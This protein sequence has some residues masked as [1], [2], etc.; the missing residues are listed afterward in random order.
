MN[1]GDVMRASLRCTTAI[2][3]SSIDTRRTTHE[4]RT[5]PRDGTRRQG[6]GRQSCPEREDRC[7]H[8]GVPEQRERHAE[9]RERLP[10]Q[11]PQEAARTDLRFLQEADQGA[12]TDGVG[13]ADQDRRQRYA[14]E[15][16]RLEQP[17]Y[18]TSRREAG[19]ASPPN[20]DEGEHNGESQACSAQSAENASE[21]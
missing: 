14:G 20:L 8:H 11:Q 18:S 3:P 12:G 21:G 9:R 7:L 19:M 13:L 16:H 17:H 10:H 4:P 15:A 1:G 6:Q 2:M 5:G